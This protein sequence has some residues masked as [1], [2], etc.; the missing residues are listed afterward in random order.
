MGLLQRLKYSIEADLHQ[1]F[2]K[3]EEKIQS[4]C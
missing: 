2:D 3:K 1:F 4:R